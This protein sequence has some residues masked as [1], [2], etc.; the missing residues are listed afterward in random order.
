M[1]FNALKFFKKHFSGIQFLRCGFRQHK[2]FVTYLLM[3]EID[4]IF[5]QMISL[6][7][8]K[9]K[10]R[11]PV[12]KPRADSRGVSKK[13]VQPFFLDLGP[14]PLNDG[15]CAAKILDRGTY[16]AFFAVHR[17]ASLAVK[18]GNKE[19]AGFYLFFLQIQPPL[20]LQGN[21]LAVEAQKKSH[22]GLGLFVR[23]TKMRHAQF[24]IIKF[25]FAF[26]KNARLL[27]F[28]QKPRFARVIN[29]DQP[30]IQHMHVFSAVVRQLG[31][32]GLSVLKAFNVMAGETALVRN[33]LSAQKFEFVFR[34][35]FCQLGPGFLMP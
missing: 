16:Q 24:F 14:L 6:F 23:E 20:H 29:M 10:S 26:I 33:A 19:P 9:T 34:A 32:Y 5:H 31:A 11:H 35:H 18:L 1:A 12:S 30:E 8:I 17:V 22:K 7:L 2:P 15:R 3:R 27:Q 4:K 25:F 28:L 21:G 13:F